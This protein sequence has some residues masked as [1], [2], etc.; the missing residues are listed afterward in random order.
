[1]RKT[2][3]IKQYYATAGRLGYRGVFLLVAAIMLVST[4]GVTRFVNADSLQD[5]IRALQQENR[6]NRAAVADLMETA[7]SYK[8]AIAQLEAQ[9]ARALCWQWSVRSMFR[10]FTT[11]CGGGTHFIREPRFESSRSQQ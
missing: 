7:T 1:M 2:D 3:T 5:Q 8:H 10:S 11:R 4:V 9:I 6:N